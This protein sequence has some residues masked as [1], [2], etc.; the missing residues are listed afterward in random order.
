[1][2][3]TTRRTLSADAL[4]MIEGGWKTGSLPRVQQGLDRARALG[5]DVSRVLEGPARATTTRLKWLLRGL[6]RLA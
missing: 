2:D 4:R 1:M 6:R 3:A 5:F